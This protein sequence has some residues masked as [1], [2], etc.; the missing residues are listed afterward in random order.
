MGDFLKQKAKLYKRYLSVRNPIYLHW[1]IYNVLHWKQTK[2]I[3]NLMHI[4]GTDDHVFPIKNI[5]NCIEIKKG[6]HVMV[7]TKAKSISQHL[8]EI[9]T[10]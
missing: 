6:T 5:K 7:L 2:P 3:D 1:A 8:L 10:C 4:H 9:L